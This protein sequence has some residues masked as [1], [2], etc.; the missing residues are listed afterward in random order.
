M[1]GARGVPQPFSRI[2][3]R[4][5]GALRRWRQRWA[6]AVAPAAQPVPH[7][8][9]DLAAVD[10]FLQA[11]A[12]A[13]DDAHMRQLFQAYRAEYDLQVPVD[14]DSPAYRQQQLALYERLHGEP[15]TVTNERS[16]M[17]VA[18]MARKPYPYVHGHPD[19]VGDQ[20]MAI[21]FLI[22]SM[23]LRVGARVLE[24]GPGWGNT[25][26]ALGKMGCSV[27]AIDIEQNFVDLIRERAR[28]EWL[29]NIEVRRGEFLDIEA[30]PADSFDAVLFFECFHHC[31]DHQR[32][33]AA[34]ERVLRP[35]GVVCLAAEPIVDDFPLPWGLRMDGEALW[36]IRRNG[37]LELGF[38]T[39]YFQGLMARHGW[40]LEKR[41][42][43]DSRLATL[44]LARRAATSRSWPAGQEPLWTEVGEPCAGGVQTSGRAG[45]LSYG[46][47]TPWPAG[48]WLARLDTS[49]AA[50]GPLELEVVSG[51][52]QH[53][54][55]S[56][57]VAEA[58]GRLPMSVEFVLSAPAEDL[59]VRVRCDAHTHVL[60][61]AVTVMAGD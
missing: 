54:H 31:A 3:S 26:L 7:Q 50:A 57:A 45:Y 10:R 23:G 27:L 60:L 25:T 43:S 16:A 40:Q 49:E 20:L 47:Y 37:W 17:D 34:L 36:A 30:L 24:F 46:P 58:G 19:L 51:A 41:H 13:P 8:P 61:R 56:L 44:W 1:T 52:G 39:T 33:V 18:A 14:P 32:L 11:V 4:V 15:Y 59:E 38:N 42:G 55:A 53:V 28:M 2:H 6:A 22:K 5:K 29:D 9:L 35:G 21:G 12:A 48:R